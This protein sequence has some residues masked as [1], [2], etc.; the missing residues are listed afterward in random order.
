MLIPIIGIII[1]VIIAVFLFLVLKKVVKTIMILVGIIIIV[2][3][4]GTYFVYKDAQDM[5]E[6]FQTSP[7]VF[8]LEQDDK[9]I[10]GFQQVPDSEEPMPINDLSDYSIYPED[11]AELKGDNYKLISFKQEAFDEIDLIELDNIEHPTSFIL[12]LISSETPVDDY[13][14]NAII[15]DG[16]PQEQREEEKQNM[17]QEF[18]LTDQEFKGMLFASIFKK[19]VDEEGPI[20][21]FKQYKEGNVVVYKETAVFKMINLIPTSFI[22]NIFADTSSAVKEKIKEKI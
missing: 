13:I 10:S 8:L 11:L 7:N 16:I 19:A 1:F 12:T 9:I 20:F 2:L 6:N 3:L 14:T 4:V 18:G 17:K 5:Q 21:I 22:K 15:R